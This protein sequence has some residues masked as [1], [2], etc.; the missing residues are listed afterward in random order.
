MNIPDKKEQ[1]RKNSA[2]RSNDANAK[3]LF[4]PVID[5]FSEL[6]MSYQIEEI[7]S[8][9]I[10][11]T[12]KPVDLFLVYTRITRSQVM[13]LYVR[14]AANTLSYSRFYAWVDFT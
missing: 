2:G 9:E 11:G 4:V 12:K 1:T 8:I 13:E 10:K 6:D 5:K 3:P 7:C 14:D